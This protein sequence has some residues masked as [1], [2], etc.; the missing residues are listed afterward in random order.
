MKFPFV[1]GRFQEFC[2][3]AG[4][5]VNRVI[6]LKVIWLAE[7]GVVWGGTA[8]G[9]LNNFD[10][11]NDTGVECH[12]FEIELE[13]IRSSDI[14]STYNWNHYGTPMITED[15][16]DPLHPKVR[17]R[18]ASG[19]N[20]DGSWSAYTA[21]PDGPISPTNGHQFTNP[22]V[23]FG[24][25]H[26]GVGYRGNPGAIR[27]HWLV[28]GGGGTLVQGPAVLVATPQF[29]FMAGVNGG[30]A[31]VQAVIRPAPVERALEFGPAT[32]VKEIRTTSHN[33]GEVKLRD[34][35]SDDPE[36]NEDRNWRNGEPDEVEV[37]WQ[38]LQEEFKAD[39]GGEN[40]MLE[41]E[42]EEL[43][44]G[45]EVVTR[46]YE[47]Y[48]YLGPVDAENGEAKADKVGEDGVHGVGTKRI[49]GVEVD[50][51]TRVV[52]GKYLGA[53]MSAFDVHAPVGLI[54]QVQDGVLNEEYP[55]RTLVISGFFPFAS[56]NWGDLPEGM[57][58]GR[59]T[60][61]LSGTPMET[62][63]FQFTVEV[64][65][66][67]DPVVR[68]TFT[69]TVLEDEAAGLVPRCHLDTV[70]MPLEAGQT[71][72]DGIYGKGNQVVAMAQAAPGYVF[73]RWVENGKVV[74]ATPE[75][76]LEMNIN[77][78]LVAEFEYV[79]LG[80]RVNSR[81]KENGSV[82]LEWPAAV[83]GSVLWSARVLGAGAWTRVLEGVVVDGETNRFEVKPLEGVW[84]FRLGPP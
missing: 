8:Y 50:L 26:F 9:T 82:V 46:R 3:S 44:E 2:S 18:Y 77:R 23:N 21:I 42:P 27:Y 20:A 25:E 79:G 36:D 29:N 48:E 52:V 33:N 1:G 68:R 40:G 63:V 12:G 16:T 35:V 30:V 78:S 80:P 38:L 64:R 54:E 61:E 4:F 11:V 53:Q 70:P 47:F 65:A 28:D 57:S 32:W 41:A 71:F 22:N 62:G 39:D 81:V 59:L 14:S 13:D 7:V 6:L 51:S 72:G 17:V 75:V 73:R 10:V 37:E 5:K 31:R 34:L 15:L 55:T 58:Y 69:L 24:G 19:K 49:N 67:E 74:G 60:G 83:P 43:N 66:G 45:D 56:T 84:F 76:S